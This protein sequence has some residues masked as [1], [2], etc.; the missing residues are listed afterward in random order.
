M[1]ETSLQALR[2]EARSGDDHRSIKYYALDVEIVTQQ[3]RSLPNH[4]TQ[5]YLHNH[6]QRPSLSH[7][8]Q[9][10]PLIIHSSPQA[11]IATPVSSN[12]NGLGQ[13]ITSPSGLVS[14]QQYYFK[15][16]ASTTYL[17]I[18]HDQSFKGHRAIVGIKN[19]ALDSQK[20]CGISGS[21]FN[22]VAD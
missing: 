6:G 18:S 11:T 9:I 15:N 5:I 17:S 16:A 2:A 3:S 22:M 13:Q 7:S 14:G 20:V 10:S 21:N 1:T 8:N 4:T 19:K 12:A